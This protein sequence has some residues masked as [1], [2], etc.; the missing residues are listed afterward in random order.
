M[1]SIEN[2]TLD[3]VYSSAATGPGK[4]VNDPRKEPNGASAAADATHRREQAHR[5]ST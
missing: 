3:A 2:R 5:R 1:R 4:P